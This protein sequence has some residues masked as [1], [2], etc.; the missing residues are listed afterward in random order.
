[1]DVR[2]Q[3]IVISNLSEVSSLSFEADYQTLPSSSFE[4]FPVHDIFNYLRDIHLSKAS[5]LDISDCVV[6]YVSAP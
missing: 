2:R 1:M 5:S 3:P 6:V 4:I